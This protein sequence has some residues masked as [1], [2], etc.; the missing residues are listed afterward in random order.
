M[1]DYLFA[2]LSFFSGVARTLDLGATFDTYNESPTPEMA[3]NIALFLDLRAVG[4]DLAAGGE[5]FAQELEHERAEKA[6]S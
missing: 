5:R 2:H 6:T 3:D 4:E 1:S